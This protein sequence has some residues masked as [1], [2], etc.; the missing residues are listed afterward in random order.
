MAGDEHHRTSTDA[1]GGSFPADWLSS[2]QQAPLPASAALARFDA[3]AGVDVDDVIGRWR[4]YGL[5]SGH[6]LDG[7]LE[8]YG[9]YGKDFQDTETVR[10]LLFGSKGGAI[11]QIDPGRLPLGLAR[12]MPRLARGRLAAGVFAMMRPLLATSRST[13]RLRMIAYRGPTSAA[14][15]YDSLPIIDHLRRVD[16]TH[17]L[18]AMDL[19]S[20]PQPFFF[21]L[22]REKRS[23]GAGSPSTL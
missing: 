21:L 15:V 23:V 14:I 4:G 2:W 7:V 18:G 8:R 19:R 20:E 5:A 17:I 3:L 11:R 22:A 13:A 9:W 6:W 1:G 16:D 12:A 10:P